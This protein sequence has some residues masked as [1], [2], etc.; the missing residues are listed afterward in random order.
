MIR[1]RHLLSGLALAALVLT[2]S[3]A[4][5][6]GAAAKP[7][8][9]EFII[10]NTWMGVMMNYDLYECYTNSEEDDEVQSPGGADEESMD[11]LMKGTSPVRSQ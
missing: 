10:N 9:P 1:H 11:S 3:L 6:D 2:P 5:A 8:T 4:F 7:I